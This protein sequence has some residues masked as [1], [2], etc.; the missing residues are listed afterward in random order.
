M[1]NRWET[2]GGG[3]EERREN[4]TVSSAR[5][6]IAQQNTRG[7]GGGSRTRRTDVF[8][9]P[10]VYLINAVINMRMLMCFIALALLRALQTGQNSRARNTQ[11][12]EILFFLSC[13][14]PFRSSHGCARCPNN[15]LFHALPLR[16]FNEKNG[17]EINSVS[18]FSIL[19]TPI[20]KYGAILK[21]QMSNF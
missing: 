11:S 4:E 15:C 6:V 2:G 3:G 16:L 5:N 21:E 10:R 14:S 12:F 13:A 1:E 7:E 9:A 8:K 17:D 18:F 20:H 19:I